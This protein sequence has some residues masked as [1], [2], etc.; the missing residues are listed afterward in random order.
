MKL[1]CADATFPPKYTPLSQIK[2]K[3]S[4]NNATF[5]RGKCE[6][7]SKENYYLLKLKTVGL[8]SNPYLKKV[9]H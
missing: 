9:V 5:I 1:L 7:K 8:D 2:S 4:C 6:T 3:I